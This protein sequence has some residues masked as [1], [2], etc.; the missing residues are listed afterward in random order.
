MK[1][2]LILTLLVAYS[3][4]QNCKEIRKIVGEN[5]EFIII[6]DSGHSI[7]IIVNSI[8]KKVVKIENKTQKEIKNEKD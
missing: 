3:F 8:T 4:A 1:V 7:K 5:T 6:C 2:Y